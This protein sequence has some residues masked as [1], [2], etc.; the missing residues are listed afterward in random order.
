MNFLREVLPSSLFGFELPWAEKEK[1]QAPSGTLTET[2]PT[3]PHDIG[4]H[5]VP[6]PV[7]PVGQVAGSSNKSL[8]EDLGLLLVNQTDKLYNAATASH[9]LARKLTKKM[10]DVDAMTREVAETRQKDGSYMLTDNFRELT[11]RLR[12]QQVS[13]P[14][15]DASS[16]T[17]EEVDALQLSLRQQRE[18]FSA[19]LN[20][21][22]QKILKNAEQH[23]TMFQ[24]FSSCL[25]TLREAT[26]KIMGGI[27][28]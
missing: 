13:L 3:T 23:N 2:P 10:E 4:T 18:D 24:F 20:R 15:K 25:H 14:L 21:E 12:E 1:S 8:E 17:K 6:P 9:E 19:E 11:K 22:G 7:P 28:R 5:D 27:S 16:L 26:R